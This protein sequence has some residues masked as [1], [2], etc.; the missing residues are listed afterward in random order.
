MTG[1]SVLMHAL[2]IPVVSG[3]IF[4]LLTVVAT[5]RFVVRRPPPD[6]KSVV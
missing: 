2:L 6:R 5:W 4:S 1:P 3:S